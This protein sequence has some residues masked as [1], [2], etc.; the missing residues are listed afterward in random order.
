MNRLHDV[1][2]ATVLV[3]M[4]AAFATGTAMAQDASAA[5]CRFVVSTDGV[6]PLTLTVRSGE[7][8]TVSLTGKGEFGF[9][10]TLRASDGDTADFEILD[11]S[12]EPP[13]R[14]GMVA[15]K[16]GGEAVTSDTTPVFTVRLTRVVR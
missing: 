11:T 10:P 9:R 16:A 6:P 12:V 13:K 1:G 5:A 2:L 3:M 14:L 15:A 4:S 7:T 8:A